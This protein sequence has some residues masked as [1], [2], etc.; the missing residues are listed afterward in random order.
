MSESY[1]PT[2]SLIADSAVV[3][4]DGRRDLF[5]D[6]K[7]MAGVDT[8]S[9][10]DVSARAGAKAPRVGGDLIASDDGVFKVVE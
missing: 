5:K 6:F 7:R 4:T 3:K 8:V 2:K 9:G 10:M 1:A